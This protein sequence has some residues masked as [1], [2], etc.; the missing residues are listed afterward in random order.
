MLESITYYNIGGIPFIVYLGI[1]AIILFIAAAYT[2]YK[3]KPI[4]IH[5]GLAI[6]GIVFAAVHFLLAILAYI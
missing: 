5:K 1:I 3:N 6:G 2:G 4:K